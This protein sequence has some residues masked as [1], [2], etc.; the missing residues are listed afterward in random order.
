MLTSKSPASVLNDPSASNPTSNSLSANTVSLELLRGDRGIGFEV[1]KTL[2]YRYAKNMETYWRDVQVISEKI[3]SV[4]E[5]KV[6]GV[7]MKKTKDVW[8]NLI[9]NKKSARIKRNVDELKEYLRSFGTKAFKEYME[10]IKQVKLYEQ[11][12][13][14]LETA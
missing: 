14:T 1:M 4:N 7:R 5:S 10:R 6:K 12:M 13:K 8:L 11:I 2:V 3:Y 9:R